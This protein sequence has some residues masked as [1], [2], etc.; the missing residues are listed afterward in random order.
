MSA[1]HPERSGSAERPLRRDAE[2]NRQRILEAA[3]DLF[4]ERGLGVTLDDI[5]HHAGVGVGTVYRRFPD[6]EQLI[7]ALFEDRM[8]G[9]VALAE[10]CLAEDDPWFG[11][12]TFFERG[13]ERQ[14]AD[15]GLKDLV[16]CTAH[17]RERVSSGR[18]RLGPVIDQLL[19]RAQRAGVVR[20]DVC[21]TDLGLLHLMLAAI[22]DATCE[23]GP[24][25]WRRLV[26][27]VLDG[28]RTG[29]RGPSEL[30]VAPLDEEQLEAAMRTLPRRSRA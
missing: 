18:E 6:K 16:T 4:A 2:R 23:V 30:A 27:L 1:T 25:V 3:T 13:L 19:V 20:D 15:R 17:G 8:D 5:A 21:H 29:D 26:R 10:A 9:L 11:L 7:D 12:S 14:A 24:D 22:M 28:L